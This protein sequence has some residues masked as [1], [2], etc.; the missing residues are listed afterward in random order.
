[1]K[2]THPVFDQFK[3]KQQLAQIEFNEK[4][5]TVKAHADRNKIKQPS[6]LLLCLLLSLTCLCASGQTKLDTSKYTRVLT[7]TPTR[8]NYWFSSPLK[9]LG[10]VFF[11]T[12][13][14]VLSIS[15]PDSLGYI[16]IKYSPKLMIRINDTTFKFKNK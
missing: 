6:K 13:Q 16:T 11:N 8:S 14:A 1:M 9:P 7:L 4:N 10:F 5:P 2:T 12:P 15:S 3:L